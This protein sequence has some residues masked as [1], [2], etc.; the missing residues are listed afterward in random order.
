MT[1]HVQSTPF[2]LLVPDSREEPTLVTERHSALR[3]AIVDRFQVAATVRDWASLSGVYV[4][5][6]NPTED[7]K[8][9]AYVGEA[10]GG[11]GNRLRTHNSQRSD[12][13]RALLVHR[14]ATQGFTSTEAA[15]LEGELYDY[16]D[17][18]ANVQLQNKRQPRDRTLPPHDQA[19]L[20]GT[21]VGV[22]AAVLRAIGCDLGPLNEKE[23][24][25][26]EEGLAS[27]A[28]RPLTPKIRFRDLLE[29]NFTP[30]GTILVSVSPSWPATAT[31]LP[32]GR[33]ELEGSAY[34]TPS[35]AGKAVREGKETN[36]WHFWAV[37]TPKGLV[38]LSALRT[39]CAERT[40]T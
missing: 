29:Q 26:A 16:L 33:I 22:V 21:V 28:R 12:W 20:K 18:A 37:E 5:I 4:L 17:Q 11:L 2:T 36:G 10:S 39:R 19:R 38:R 23:R 15:W 30:P 24:D 6:C 7:G 35:A 25:K 40:V 9:Q 32:D 27:Q 34:S 3:M 13:K 8:W 1:N 31:V 14:D